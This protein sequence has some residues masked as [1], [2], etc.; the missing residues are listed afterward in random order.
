MSVNLEK[1]Q[2]APLQSS[3]W[4]KKCLC[5]AFSAALMAGCAS[6]P[7]TAYDESAADQVEG[8]VVD[9]DGVDEGA[10]G[11]G[12]DGGVDSD[13]LAQGMGQDSQLREAV[14]FYFDFDLAELKPEAFGPLQ[15][16]ARFLMEN[17]AAQIRLFGHGDERGTREYNIA[18]GERRAKS[19]AN[20]LKVQGVNPGQLE[21]ISYGEERPAAYG[22]SEQAW[23]L[24][25]RVELVY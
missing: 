21:V 11:L 7:D 9:S 4:Y 14:V 15:A 19:V 17:P 12:S 6:N 20:Y 10:T 13:V 2:S 25:R 1:S 8:Q 16:H 22:N 23:A 18:L 5:V 3:H 24:N